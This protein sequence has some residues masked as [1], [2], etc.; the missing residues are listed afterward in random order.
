MFDREQIHG[1]FPPVS[2]IA[3]IEA[4]LPNLTVAELARVELAVHRQFRERG[5][6]IVYDDAHGVETEADLL[7]SADEAFQIYDKTEAEHA[8]RKLR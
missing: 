1:Y 8:Q 7:A 5:S 2:T 3:E 4:V 6:G